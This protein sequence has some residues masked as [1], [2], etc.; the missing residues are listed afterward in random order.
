MIYLFKLNEKSLQK[1][2]KMT[3]ED[4]LLIAQIEDK[5]EQCK[6]RYIITY[7]DFLDTHQRKLVKDYCL[8]M[9]IP[10]ADAKVQTE[11]H[12]F[13]GGYGDAERS[14]VAFLPEYI[15]CEEGVP[16]EVLEIL[17]VIK[18]KAPKGGRKLGHRDY[19]GSLLGLGIDRGVT[20]DILVRDDG[21]DIIVLAEM[22]D[23][24]ELNYAKAGRTNLSLEVAPIEK[25]DV[26]EVNIEERT[27][28][29]ASLRLDSVVSSAFRLSRAKAA[30][31]IRAGL[32][33][34]NSVEEARVDAI[35]SEGDKIVL[36]G[37]GRMILAQVGGESK[38][39]RIYIKMHIYL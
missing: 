36:R 4:E 26:G 5:I 11:R 31:A 27:D 29:V 23:F 24:I 34:L 15:E 13:F 19:L 16:D 21:A 39:G 33:S 35:V 18:V 1:G 3:K 12:I 17:Q 2:M 37:K 14:I 38:K 7:S 32:V 28:T 9:K 8:K 20:G 10:P 30:D 25:L 22:A 6:D